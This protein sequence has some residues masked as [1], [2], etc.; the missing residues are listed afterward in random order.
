SLR[1]VAASRPTRDDRSTVTA[2]DPP[3]RQRDE[4]PSPENSR[5]PKIRS[6]VSADA[7]GAGSGGT[8]GAEQE[9]S[10]S[11]RKSRDLMRCPPFRGASSNSTTLPECVGTPPWRRSTKACR[12]LSSHRGRGA[13]IL[14]LSTGA[15]HEDRPEKDSRPGD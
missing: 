3:G 7:S 14:G 1:P 8:G 4:C 12:S 2:R 10:A 11:I 6:T 5:L 13:T 9:L 15:R